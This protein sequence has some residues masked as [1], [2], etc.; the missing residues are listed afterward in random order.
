MKHIW[1]SSTVVGTLLASLAPVTLNAQQRGNASVAAPPNTN[2][3]SEPAPKLADGHP[4]LSGVW[5]TGG[6]VGGRGYNSSRPGG[7]GAP[8]PQTFTG[9]Y[10]AAAAEAAKK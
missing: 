9:L 3:P 7:R 1:I 5:W 2:R 8:A 6:D 10:N 4:D